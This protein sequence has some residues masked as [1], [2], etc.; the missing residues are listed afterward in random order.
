M[1]DCTRSNQMPLADQ[2]VARLSDLPCNVKTSKKK[3]YIN[4]VHFHNIHNSVFCYLLSKE[5]F[6]CKIHKSTFLNNCSNIKVSTSKSEVEP[7]L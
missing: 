1:C 6:S 2:I 7:N 3:K 4:I 5:N